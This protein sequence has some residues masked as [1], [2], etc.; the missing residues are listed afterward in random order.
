MREPLLDIGPV[1]LV[2]CINPV[3]KD[4]EEADVC[5]ELAVA[6][7]KIYKHLSPL[8]A[9]LAEVE[10]SFDSN[11]EVEGVGFFDENRALISC[12]TTYNLSRDTDEPL[13]PEFSTVCAGSSFDLQQSLNR[14]FR[15]S[16]VPSLP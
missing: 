13:H 6:L 12:V 8:R 4:L 16:A 2:E 15:Y 1:Y 3:T 5:R 11:G 14:I 10:V 7:D 9:L